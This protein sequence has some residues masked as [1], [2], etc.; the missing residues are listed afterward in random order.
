MFRKSSRSASNASTKG[1]NPGT[2]GGGG[3]TDLIFPNSIP[4]NDD[5][6]EEEKSDT[7]PKDST[8]P[9]TSTLKK[10]SKQLSKIPFQ[11]KTLSKDQD[12][13][14]DKNKSSAKQDSEESKKEPLTSKKSLEINQEIMLEANGTL[15]RK[16]SVPTSGE[17]TVDE[18]VAEYL[19]AFAMKQNE[20]I[21]ELEEKLTEKESALILSQNLYTASLSQIL[22]LKEK[23]SK[24]DDLNRKNGNALSLLT[25]CLI[26]YILSPK[27]VASKEDCRAG[28][29]EF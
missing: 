5:V 10:L 25:S 23:L 2:V 3:G 29:R 11:R 28:R 27:R 22:T 12:G 24:E 19:R 16:T 8:I 13:A 4:V 1:N 21:A 17:N 18:D 7:K 9:R 14:E 6:L 15:P 26:Y 20:K